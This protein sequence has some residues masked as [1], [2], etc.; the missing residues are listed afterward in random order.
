[1]GALLWL[2]MAIGLACG[3][4]HAVYVSNC[5]N[6]D[7]ALVTPNSPDRREWPLLRYLDNGAMAAVRPLC[8]GLGRCLLLLHSEPPVRSPIHYPSPTRRAATRRKKIPPIGPHLQKRRTG[9]T[10]FLRSTVSQSSAPALRGW[11]PP[12][13]YWPRGSTARYSNAVPPSATCGPMAISILASRC[14]VSFTSFPI[15]RSGGRGEFHAG[16]RISRLPLR[17]CPSFRGAA[18]YPL[19]VARCSG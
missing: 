14:S 5:I 17:L 2:G 10:I 3:L 9:Q 7:A 11:Q 16:A 13:F 18:A 1:M 19:R 12:A 15:G 8:N 4:A 6:R